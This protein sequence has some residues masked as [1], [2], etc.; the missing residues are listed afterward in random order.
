VGAALVDKDELLGVERGDL[1]AP[2]RPG[3]LVAL[4]GCQCLFLCV[5]PTRRMA[6]HIV[7]SLNCCP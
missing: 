2:R 1:L 7:A 6:R 3:R 5:Q 4:T